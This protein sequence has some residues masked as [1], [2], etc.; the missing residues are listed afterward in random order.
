MN[1]YLLMSTAAALATVS[2]GD[3]NAKSY[4]YSVHFGT[5]DGGSYCDGEVGHAVGAVY[6]GNHGYSNCE[7]FGDEKFPNLGLAAKGGVPPM[8]GKA[9]NGNVNLADISYYVHYQANYAV[10][11]DLETPIKAGGTWALWLSLYGSTAFIGNE[12]ILLAGPHAKR[13]GSNAV[14]TISKLNE[15]L[16]HRTAK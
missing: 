12:G 15:V 1:K 13:N 2:A 6:A 9:K 5:Q 10:T 16:K 8:G 4:S 3:A 7:G 14:S 11:F